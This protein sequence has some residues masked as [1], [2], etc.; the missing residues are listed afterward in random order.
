MIAKLCLIHQGNSLVSVSYVK[1]KCIIW[2][3]YIFLLPKHTHTYIHART[4]AH[5]HASTHTPNVL[6]ARFMKSLKKAAVIAWIDLRVP[7]SKKNT[8]VLA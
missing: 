1:L 6:S 2:A 4:D 7:E 8:E 3:K 5:T